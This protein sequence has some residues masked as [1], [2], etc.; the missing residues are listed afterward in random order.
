MGMEYLLLQH[1]G[2]C[3]TQLLLQLLHLLFQL[4]DVFLLFVRIQLAL[5][6]L[7][8]GLQGLLVL[9]GLGQLLIF[10]L[11]RIGEFLN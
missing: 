3:C 4:S 5:Q 8:L 9:L 6:L 1:F 7:Q 11:E 2:I 10:L